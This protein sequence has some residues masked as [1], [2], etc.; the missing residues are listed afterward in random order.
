[1]TVQIR[2]EQTTRRWI[3]ENHEHIL[4]LRYA[5][6]HVLFEGKSQFQT[7]TIVETE[8]FGRM[9][10]NDGLVMISERDEFIYHEMIAHVP[11]FTH[12]HA[13]KVLVIGGGDGGT[14]REVLRHSQVEYCHMVEIDEMVVDACKQWIPQTAIGMTNNLRFKL[15]IADAVDY[16]AITNQ[17][18][19]IVLV[20]STDPIGPAVPLF[21]D[22]FYCNVYRILADDGIVV[23]QGESPVYAAEQQQSLLKTMGKLFPLVSMYNYNNMTYPGGLWSFAIASKKYHPITALDTS[24]VADSGI[25]FSWYNPAVHQASFVL[26]Q[27]MLDNLRGLLKNNLDVA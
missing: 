12:P 25:N 5:L 3:E 18:Y 11:L 24:R 22:K 27:F 23:A 4:T 2:T 14:A 26:P 7:V 19:D 8:G 6:K 1:M 10:L 20:D 15:D 9:L 21:G 16:V 13:K 17:R